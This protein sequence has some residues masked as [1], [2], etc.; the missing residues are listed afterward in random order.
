MIRIAAVLVAALTLSLGLAYPIQ[1]QHCYPT[2]QR[3]AAV[4]YQQTAYPAQKIVSPYVQGI[5]YA[6][7]AVDSYPVPVQAYAAPYY[8]SVSESYRDKAYLRDVIREELRAF[9]SSQGAP[10]A[11]PMVAP[12]AAANPQRP[13]AAVKPGLVP[14]DLTPPDLQAKV[15]AAYQGRANCISCHAGAS[16]QGG[17]RLVL[18][19]G[20]G[21][22]KLVKYD[23]PMRWKIYGMAAV[24]AMPPAAATDSGKAMEV[25]HLTNMLQYAATKD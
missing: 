8:Y 25:P 5:A 10:A 23:S 7:V 13:P 11:A 12:P 2:N 21:G 3:V 19:D 24:G 22:Y 17:L 15:L 14:D 20:A 4:A 1:G 9:A 18:D 6:P 16:P